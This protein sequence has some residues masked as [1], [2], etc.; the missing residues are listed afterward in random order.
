M[1]L[2]GSSSHPPEL[3]YGSRL[4]CCWHHEDEPSGAY[5]VCLECGHAYQS[6]EDLLEAWSF[7]YLNPEE[8]PGCAFCLHDW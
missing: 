6:A 2:P 3:C 1:S 4:H 8:V 7:R 5:A